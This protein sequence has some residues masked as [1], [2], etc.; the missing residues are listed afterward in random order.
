[1]MSIP[2]NGANGPS[3]PRPGAEAK[4]SSGNFVR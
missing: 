4:V 3:G 2:A 1:M